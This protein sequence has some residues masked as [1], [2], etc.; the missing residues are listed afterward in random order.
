MFRTMP[1]R[2]RSNLTGIYFIFYNT[3]HVINL[4]HNILLFRYKDVT[5]FVNFI[6]LVFII[7]F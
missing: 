1:G 4:E 2:S 7:E 5:A 6:E 3:L